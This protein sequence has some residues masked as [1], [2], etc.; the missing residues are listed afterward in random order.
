MTA[1]NPKLPVIFAIT[2]T[3]KINPY[4]EWDFDKKEPGPTQKTNIVVKEH[5]VS[6]RFGIPTGNIISIS[7]EEKFNL[8]ELVDLVVE[9]LPNEKKYSFARE[10]KKENVSKKIPRKR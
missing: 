10:A 6:K 7:S 4:R 2:Q 5:D 8:V 1:K 9:L 3:D